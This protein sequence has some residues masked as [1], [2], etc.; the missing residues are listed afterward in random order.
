[1][2]FLIFLL[3]ISVLIDFHFIVLWVSS[4]KITIIIHTPLYVIIIS[5][6]LHL[7]FNLSIPIHR[8]FFVIQVG[9]LNISTIIAHSYW[10]SLIFLGLP[11]L[12]LRSQVVT[13]IMAEAP[14]K[15]DLY[16][17]DDLTYYVLCNVTRTTLHS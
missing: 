15:V 13:L 3:N 5:I 11:S 12:G 7:L 14:M 6:I 9:L 16:N 10:L 2:L 4:F 8:H 17:F 1:M